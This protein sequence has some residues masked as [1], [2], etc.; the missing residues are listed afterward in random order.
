MLPHP[1]KVP[2]PIWLLAVKDRVRDLRHTVHRAADHW[3]Q[4]PHKQSARTPAWALPL[5]EVARKAW[6][7]VQ[8]VDR[9]AVDLLSSTSEYRRMNYRLRS[10]LDGGAASLAWASAQ[11]FQRYFYWTF[12]HLLHRAQREDVSV[13][14][15]AIRRAWQAWCETQHLTPGLATDDADPQAMADLQARQCARLVIAL[16]KQRPLHFLH[17]GLPLPV[18]IGAGAPAA[19]GA[20]LTLRTVLAGVLAGEIAH[21]YPRPGAVEEVSHALDLACTLVAG[22]MPQWNDALHAARAQEALAR[23]FAFVLRHI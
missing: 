21:A 9:L 11:D 23:E 6:Q 16:C 3:L 8:G 10:V 2:P 18:S 19:D 14:E 1:D 13:H 20:A 5:D 17:A 12:W 15:E 7:V 22:R 4:G